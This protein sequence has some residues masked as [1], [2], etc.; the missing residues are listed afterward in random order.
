MH[1][2][3]LLTSERK[4]KQ[5]VHY[6]LKEESSSGWRMRSRITVLIKEKRLYHRGHSFNDIN[7]NFFKKRSLK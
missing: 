4:K 7:L 6:V 1:A 2:E 3:I 5:V